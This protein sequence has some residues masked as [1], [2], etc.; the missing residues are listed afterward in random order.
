MINVGEMAGAVTVRPVPLFTADQWQELER[1]TL[2]Y[3]YMM[4]SLPVPPQLLMSLT[5]GPS[6]PPPYGAGRCVYIYLKYLLMLP[7]STNFQIEQFMY[8][9][10]FYSFEEFTGVGDFKQQL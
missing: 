8:W 2:I 5:K 10:V 4:A 3:K 7:F 1:Q 9:W 6:N